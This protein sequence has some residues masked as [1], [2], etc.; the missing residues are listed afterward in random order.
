MRRFFSFKRTPYR[1]KKRTR[2]S[3]AKRGQKPPYWTASRGRR[4]TAHLL[5]KIRI[6]SN[7]QK[8][9]QLNFH[10]ESFSWQKVHDI[11]W[12]SFWK[13][14]DNKAWTFA[15]KR[16]AKKYRDVIGLLPLPCCTSGH[17]QPPLVSLVTGSSLVLMKHTKEY[18]IT[19]LRMNASLIVKKVVTFRFV[20]VAGDSR[21]FCCEKLW[22]PCLQS[23]VSKKCHCQT[24][25]FFFSKTLLKKV[26]FYAPRLPRG[27]RKK[28]KSSPGWSS[29]LPKWKSYATKSPTLIR[30][31]KGKELIVLRWKCHGSVG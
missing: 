17:V 25:M 28:T 1:I 5:A 18:L 14:V 10:L 13:N 31:E 4:I 27:Q 23:I 3:S 24:T 12:K 6:K 2:S 15:K 19:R 22:K 8:A 30:A 20:Q 26:G 21:E 29:C 9:L 16:L 11:F 7:K